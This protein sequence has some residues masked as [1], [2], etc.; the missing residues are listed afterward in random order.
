MK[1][2][3]L[4]EFSVNL[5]ISFIVVYTIPFLCSAQN[6]DDKL[7][8][9]KVP[10]PNNIDEAHSLLLKILDKETIRKFKNTAQEDIGGLYHMGLGA[11][12]RNEWGLWDEEDNKLR[13]YFHELG[14]EHPDNIS[15]IILETFWLKL[16]KKPVNMKKILDPYLIWR[17]C[18]MPEETFLN[19]ET[20][21]HWIISHNS[22]SMN[23]L[24]LGIKDSDKSFWRWEYCRDKEIEKVTAENE[25]I[26][27]RQWLDEHGGSVR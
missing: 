27:L 26:E 22:G 19:D 13:K 20:T 1:N 17:K 14:I 18:S 7:I 24:G 21:I 23:V 25:M 6:L 9:K 12:I 10:I 5:L 2:I 3:R 8:E 4:Q 11:W 16:N 15:G